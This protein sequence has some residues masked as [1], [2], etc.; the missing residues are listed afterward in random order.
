MD[1]LEVIKNVVLAL[2]IIGVA[3]LLG[4]M[5]TQMKAMKTGTTKIV[6]AIFHGAWTML[7]TGIILVGMDY[8]LGHPPNNIKI[9]V[10]LLLLIVI[11]VISFM[12]KK[13]DKLASWVLPTLMVLTIANIVI[14]TTWH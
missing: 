12:N 2:H 14:A 10:K 8:P 13:K 5:L 1:A 7:A 6:P 4:G 11:F 3:S 9:S